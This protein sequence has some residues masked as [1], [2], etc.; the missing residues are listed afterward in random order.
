MELL[1][2]LLPRAD[3]QINVLV[4]MIHMDSGIG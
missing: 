2:W 1:P 3:A 4:D